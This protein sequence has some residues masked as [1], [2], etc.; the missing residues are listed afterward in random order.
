MG[1][2][3]QVTAVEAGES[4]KASAPEY[5]GALGSLSVNA[6]LTDVLARGVEELRAAESAGDL[7]ETA[8]CSLAVAEA[9]RRLGR[10]AE[11]DQ[12]WKA[13]YRAARAAGDAAAMAWA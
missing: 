2:T 7:K 3:E 10:T 9:C 1:L 13:G 12:A 6:S 11:A 4:G 5:Q 8:R